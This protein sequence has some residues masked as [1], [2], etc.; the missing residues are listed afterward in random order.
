MIVR[1]DE[2]AQKAGLLHLIRFK[3]AVA[4][5]CILVF[6]S[7]YEVFKLWPLSLA[8]TIGMAALVLDWL[9]KRGTRR[10]I[11]LIAEWP[12]VLESLESAIRSG[13]NLVDSF[14]DLAQSHN[15]T[16]SPQFGKTVQL[17]ESGWLLDQVLDELKAG[18]GTVASDLTIEVLRQAG[19]SGGY[20]LADALLAQANDLRHA[21]NDLA[22]IAAKQGWVLGTAKLA[23]AAPWVV[24]VLVAIRPE[25]A[26]LFASASGTLV[27]LV[28]LTASIVAYR[29]VSRIGHIPELP[30][31]L[32]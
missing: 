10:T 3:A 28:G 31:V 6:A 8:L 32:A 17:L 27:M 12:V 7:S 20:G 21:E 4:A 25:N 19:L 14:R 23:V 18:L 11:Q 1:F 2:L 26:S 13:L 22:Q 9:A 29:L 24:L 5:G 15:L 16:C 30:R